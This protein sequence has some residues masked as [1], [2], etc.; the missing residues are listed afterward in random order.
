[1]TY[2]IG[3]NRRL[4]FRSATKTVDVPKRMKK[5]RWVVGK[6]RDGIKFDLCNNSIFVLFPEDETPAVKGN[7]IVKY[8]H[9]AKFAGSGFSIG[10]VFRKVNK[11]AEF[12]KDDVWLAESHKDYLMK[13]KDQ[14]EEKK[15]LDA[16]EKGELYQRIRD[17]LDKGLTKLI[18]RN[19]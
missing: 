1:M 7:K 16:R 10:M 2:T 8:K 17:T 6:L 18:P 19:K 5:Q 4:F 11:T 12:D 3:E 15:L 9:T 13:Y 14:V